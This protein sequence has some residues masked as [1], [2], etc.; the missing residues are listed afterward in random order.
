LVF[1]FWFLVC[2]LLVVGWLAFDE[3][4]NPKL[5]TRNQKPKTSDLVHRVGVKK[6]TAGMCDL[7][8]DK[9]VFGAVS[10]FPNL[11]ILAGVRPVL[12]NRRKRMKSIRASAFSMAGV[13]PYPPV[14]AFFLLWGISGLAS[15]FPCLDSGLP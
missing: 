4:A 7:V 10:L 11:P 1:G 6:V 8:Y 2:G 12:R 5:K 13:D 15:G 9:G 3:R 14:N